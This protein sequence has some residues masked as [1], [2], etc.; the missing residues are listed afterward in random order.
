MDDYNMWETLE[1]VFVVAA[2]ALLLLEH[3]DGAILSML[4][5]V[6][7]LIKSYE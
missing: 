7:C 5:A 1:K 6:Y 4:V 2:A 3:C